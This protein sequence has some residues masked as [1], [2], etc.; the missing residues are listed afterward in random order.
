MQESSMR[1][2]I[3]GSIYTKTYFGGVIRYC[4]GLIQNLLKKGTDIDVLTT[5]EKASLKELH[6]NNIAM[7]E[8]CNEKHNYNIFHS[9]L[10]L[11]CPLKECGRVVTVHDMIDE[12]FPEYRHGNNIDNEISGRK[13][14]CIQNAN[15]VITISNTTKKDLLKFYD[16]PE[17]KITVIYHGIDE[18]FFE[19]DKKSKF[20]KHMFF[21]KHDINTPFI[22]TV[23]GRA[24]HKN[25]INLLKAYALSKVNKEFDLVAVGS[26]EYFFKD[27]FEIIKKYH[28]KDKVKLTG[29][30]TDEELVAAY[31]SAALF[32]FPSLCEGFGIPLI[33]AMACGTPIA[34]S[35]IPT[36]REINGG[37]PIVFDPL[38]LESIVYALEEGVS[39]Y[40]KERVE[41]GKK[42][43]EVFKWEKTIENV[44]AVYT[45]A[46]LN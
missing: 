35:N 31:F 16:V 2:L 22:L 37:I 26:Q 39:S 41:R 30:L 5:P 18:I 42:H 4:N 40:D 34:C 21:K 36:F 11:G 14:E 12:L 45:K 19:T 32:V 17:N 38:N 8:T 43:A 29:Y 9:V 25:F 28:L 20:H 44:L 27:E 15:Q 1:V 6:L 23:G 13:W 46:L 10:Y 33:E 24:G 7:I 3:D